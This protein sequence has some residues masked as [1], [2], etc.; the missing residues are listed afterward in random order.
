MAAVL[1]LA[2]FTATNHAANGP[3]SEADYH[4]AVDAAAQCMAQAGFEVEG[5][6]LEPNGW[7]WSFSIGGLGAGASE[8]ERAAF[9]AR[10]DASYSGCMRD[11]VGGLENA[12]RRSRIV[13]A[14]RRPAVL[15]E[16]VSCARQAGVDSL[17]A[18]DTESEIETKLQGVDDVVYHQVNLCREQFEGLWPESIPD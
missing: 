3:I 9:E 8:A 6:E 16:F 12:Y 2:G 14:E 13:P 18:S 15:Q 7:R 5:P 4:A 1:L 11:H 17:E 10:L